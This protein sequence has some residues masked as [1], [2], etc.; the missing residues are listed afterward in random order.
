MKEDHCFDEVMKKLKSK[1]RSEN[2]EGMSRFGIKGDGRL[3]LS[4]PELR[5]MGKSIGKDHGLA[6][7]LWATKI[8]DAM[9]LAAL[10][11]DPARVTE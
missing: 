1:A 10:V 3:G 5:K 9:I 6:L 2:I 11:D 4:M 7:K 8:P